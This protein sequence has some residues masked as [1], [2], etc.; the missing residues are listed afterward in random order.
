MHAGLGE[1]HKLNST[2][3]KTVQNVGLSQQPSA[4][5]RAAV[6][7]ICMHRPTIHRDTTMAAAAA[8]TATT[9][10]ICNKSITR[11]C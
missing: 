4:A 8:A 2:N 5:V 11:C 10:H 1:L 3:R 6:T 7:A 9:S